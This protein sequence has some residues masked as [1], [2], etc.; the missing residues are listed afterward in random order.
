MHA[1]ALREWAGVSAEVQ[2]I[3]FEDAA[4]GPRRLGLL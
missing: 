1:L 3:P 4:H 2:L